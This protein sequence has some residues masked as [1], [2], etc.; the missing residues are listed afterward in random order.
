MD[1]IFIILFL[2]IYYLL[3]YLIHFQRFLGQNLNLIFWI[4]FFFFSATTT[5]LLRLIVRDLIRLIS[6]GSND[7]SLKNI[8]IQRG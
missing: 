8:V 2:E 4:L 5:G 3:S 1:I 6:K 7:K